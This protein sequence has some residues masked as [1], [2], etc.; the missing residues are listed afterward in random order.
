MRL[1]QFSDLSD[2]EF[3]AIYLINLSGYI[4]ED[5]VNHVSADERKE[6]KSDFILHKHHEKNKYEN[7]NSE[8]EFLQGNIPASLD[9]TQISSAWNIRD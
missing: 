4:L 6:S 8:T 2:E 9:L 1:N 7:K 5:Q 3:S